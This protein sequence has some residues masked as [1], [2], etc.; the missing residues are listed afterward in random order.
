MEVYHGRRPLEGHRKVIMMDK[1]EA[2]LRTVGDRG[3]IVCFKFACL[4]TAWHAKF[5]ASYSVRLAYDTAWYAYTEACACNPGRRPWFESSAPA[6][7]TG[8]L[9]VKGYVFSIK[10]RRYGKSKV[11]TQADRTYL[12]ALLHV[13]ENECIF[14]IGHGHDMGLAGM[15]QCTHIRTMHNFF[16]TTSQMRPKY[17]AP[18]AQFIVSLLFAGKCEWRT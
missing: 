9:T 14:N 18:S 5:T 7:S 8:P 17:A 11:Y 16:A 10:C 6:W 12:L 1:Q 2:P 4:H 3:I 13:L 15:P